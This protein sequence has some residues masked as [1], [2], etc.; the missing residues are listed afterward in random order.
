MT[1]VEYSGFEGQYA[2]LLIVIPVK[3]GM[4]MGV[5]GDAL[6]LLICGLLGLGNG[7]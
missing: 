3:A 7:L 5:C 6:R 4:T 1:F 2:R